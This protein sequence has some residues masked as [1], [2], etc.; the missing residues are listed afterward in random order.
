MAKNKN[1]DRVFKELRKR[2]LAY[3]DTV[4]DH[5]WGHS[6]FKVKGKTFLFLYQE[7]TFLSMSMKLPAS[8]K[9]ALNLPFTSP[10]E[11]GLGKSGW[12]TSRFELAAEP[13]LEMLLEWLD[14]SFRAIAPKASLAKQEGRS[15]KKTT[16]NAAAKK[17]RRK[18]V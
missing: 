9:T 16:P 18:T 5:P 14:E 11:Y 8:G 7:P 10:T 2:A 17:K 13:P 1:L 4:E 12:V 3:P 15:D 6:A